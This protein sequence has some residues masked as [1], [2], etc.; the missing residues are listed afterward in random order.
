MKNG[1]SVLKLLAVIFLAVAGILVAEGAAV[2]LLV[3]GTWLYAVIHCSIGLIFLIVSL[4]CFLVYQKA[5]GKKRKLLE[6]GKFVYA[7]VVDITVNSHQEIQADRIAMNPYYIKCRY[8]DENGKEYWFQSGPLLYNP[9][10]LMQSDQLKVYV[11][12]TRPSYYY[13]DT[14]AILPETAVL[15]KFKFDSR[16]NGELLIASGRYV[17]AVTCGV[18]LVG[19]IGV[20]GMIKPG[21]VSLPENIARQYGLSLDEQGHVISGYTVLCKYTAPDGVIHIFASVY[22]RGEPESDYIDEKVK[23][24]YEGKNFSRYHVEL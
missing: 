17:T 6:A 15:H 22:M 19:R 21:F 1:Q 12:F 9:S 14:N 20:N 13:V 23:V 16:K 8:M 24:F 11:D 3:N 2:G 4:I 10:G 7:T 5:S 18:E